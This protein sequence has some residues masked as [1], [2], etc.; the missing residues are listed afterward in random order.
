[1]TLTKLERYFRDNSDQKDQLLQK[2]IE[3]YI[4]LEKLYRKLD[5]TLNTD[6]VAIVVENST[7]KFVKINPAITEKQRLNT[8]LLEL[9]KNIKSMMNPIRKNAPKTPPKGNKGG[10]V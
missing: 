3:R 4:D 6:G 7:Q 1:M 8:Q 2:K 9:E 10:L 5:K